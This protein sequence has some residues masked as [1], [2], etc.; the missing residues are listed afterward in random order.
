L[1]CFRPLP[2]GYVL[3]VVVWA[4]AVLIYLDLPRWRAAVLAALLA[5][6]SLLTCLMV[7]GALEL[8]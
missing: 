6:G 1:T 3:G 7:L 8:F 5:T 4:S 2:V